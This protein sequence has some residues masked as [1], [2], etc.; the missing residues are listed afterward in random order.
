MNKVRMDLRKGGRITLTLSEQSETRVTKTNKKPTIKL[1][2]D[3]YGT[4]NGDGTHGPHSFVFDSMERVANVV[5][6]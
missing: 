4:V 3:Q 5:D 1:V 2:N 6:S